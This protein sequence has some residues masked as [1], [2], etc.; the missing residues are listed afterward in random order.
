MS[1]VNFQLPDETLPPLSPTS[2]APYLIYFLTYHSRRSQCS[3]YYFFFHSRGPCCHIFQHFLM[4]RRRSR[5]H[6]QLTFYIL[7][8]PG[9]PQHSSC[10]FLQIF[11]SLRCRAHSQ[12]RFPSVS[13]CHCRIN[14]LISIQK[15]DR[16]STR[17]NSS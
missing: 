8:R 16:K 10:S 6:S 9:S 3:I 5:Q 7:P 4:L 2:L 15:L 11:L 1:P 17:L 13:Q 14:S 12:T